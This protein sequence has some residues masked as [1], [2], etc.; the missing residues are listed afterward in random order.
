MPLP[1][2]RR[3][4]EPDYGDE[5]KVAEEN[6]DDEERQVALAALEERK[7]D[8]HYLSAAYGFVATDCL[9]LSN[10][11]CNRAVRVQF[12]AHTRT[13]P[14]PPTLN[15][16]CCAGCVPQRDTHDGLRRLHASEPSCI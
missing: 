5:E 7:R 8:G 4:D 2:T 3:L 15:T 1:S 16:E 6:P 9:S 14:S 12:V 10:Q 11:R 13:R